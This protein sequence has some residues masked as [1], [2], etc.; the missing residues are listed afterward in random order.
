MRLGW[1]RY[2]QGVSKRLQVVLD[3]EEYAELVA[4]APRAACAYGFPTGDIEEL[5]EETERGYRS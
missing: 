1:S 3:G 5:I 2:A 4:A